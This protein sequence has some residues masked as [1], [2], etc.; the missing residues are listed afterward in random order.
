[1]GRPYRQEVDRIPETVAWAEGLDPE[2]LRSLLF[3]FAG[4]NLIAV[5][6]GGSHA[7]AL[8]AA[9]LHESTFGATG[10][11]LTPLEA[12][13]RPTSH[14]TG[15]LLLS[16]R[17]NNADIL[18]AFETL[19]RR[20]YVEVA[21]VCARNGSP[22]ARRVSERGHSVFE[23]EPPSRRDGFL[24]T[25]SLVATLTLLARAYG[26][27]AGHPVPSIRVP[28]LHPHL[29][30]PGSVDLV[31]RR[32][33]LFALA[34]GWA[35]PAAADLES[36]FTEAA[37]ANVSVAD[38]RNFAHGRHHWLDRRR[39]TS[40]VVSF[41]TP[42][43]DRLA[44]R[45]LGL[46]PDDVPV[47]RVR[48]GSDGPAGTVELVC[49]SITLALAAGEA[50]GIDPGRPSVADFGR[51]LYRGS[52][53]VRAATT[54]SPWIDRK[55]TALGLPPG[56]S[57]EPIE[58][59]LDAYLD[60]LS[61]A[62]LRGLVLDYDG[63]LCS[64]D[65]RF[66]GMNEP[67]SGELSRV[68]RSGVPVAIATGRGQSAH[69]QLRDAIP[70]ALWERVIVGMYNGGVV[71]K[72]N[73]AMPDTE[74]GPPVLEEVREPLL[75][76]SKALPIDIEFRNAQVSV[77]VRSGVGLS[78][79]R[80]A[81]EEV[82]TH[83]P[84]R[85]HVRMSGHSIDI[86]PDGISKTLVVDRLIGE[87]TPPVSPD[88]VLRIGDRGARAGNDAELLNTGLSLSADAVSS[89]LETCWYLAP[90]G[91][92]GPAATLAYLR[93][94]TPAEH[95]TMSFDVNLLGKARLFP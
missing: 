29:G 25:N 2:R 61:S 46:L 92:I 44:S 37:L 12:L 42:S 66:Q 70:Q 77:R 24:A 52:A 32:D 83:T 89:S 9:Q 21:A 74:H 45:T 80:D 86:L 78:K 30:N 65:E 13:S 87:L 27:A 73:Q 38:F 71:L 36:R 48:A 95:G 6:S 51:R 91:T 26:S 35:A 28:E 90:K 19:C 84:Q 63:T 68:I 50:R 81:I 15:V 14:D 82:L 88:E 23:F 53:G 55:A 20:A 76:I 39:S 75:R 49:A 43:S 59:A 3:R 72:L 54:R 10:K 58:K 47:L 93:A 5:G 7:A 56:S 85:F 62:R 22:L 60:R 31:T 69:K 64:G 67:V 94:L 18:R 57:H 41:E 40:A 79:A 8:F 16:G 11:A 33:T 17:G 34:E 4:R 1:M